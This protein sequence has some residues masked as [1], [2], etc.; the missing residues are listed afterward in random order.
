MWEI[1]PVTSA[2]PPNFYTP[3]SLNST[4]FFSIEKTYIFFFFHFILDRD[5]FC[6]GATFIFPL[7]S[8]FFLFRQKVERKGVYVLQLLDCVKNPPCQTSNLEKKIFSPAKKIA[9]PINVASAFS[10]SSL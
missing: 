10:T 1:K 5:F 4:S 3:R 7:I 9:K 6:L 2:P 8:G